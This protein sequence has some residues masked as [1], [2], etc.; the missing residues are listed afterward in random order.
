M[1]SLI[2]KFIQGD[3]EVIKSYTKV[4]LNFVI[5]VYAQ[6]YW[7]LHMVIFHLYRLILNFTHS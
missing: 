1:H 2:I 4:T 6:P 7:N 5:D 3:S